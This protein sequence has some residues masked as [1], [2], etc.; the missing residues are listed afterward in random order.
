[1]TTEDLL[2]AEMDRQ[3][4]TDNALRAGIAAIVGGES[5][6][7]PQSERSY[8]GTNNARIRSIFQSAL[9]DKSDAFIDELK[10]DDVEF[11]NY[12][13]GPEG[14]G[15]ALGN[16]HPGDGYRYRGRGGIQLTG[17]GN[18]AKLGE[19]S[20]LDL[21]GDPDLV[22]EPVNSARIAVA[23][24]RWRYR[25]GGWEAMKDAVGNSFGSVD[26]RKNALFSRYSAS[27]EFDAPV[28]LVDERPVLRRGDRNSSVGRAQGRLKELG[29]YLHRV[30]ND[31]GPR[32]DRAV[33]DFQRGHGLVADG[34]IGR[35]TWSALLG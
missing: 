21:L 5:E 7:K 2:R 14:T 9:A 25:G 1:M 12:V 19:L 29:F 17:R 33:R 23:Y 24:M 8:R 34:V 27:G 16:T 3:R 31:F 4:V 15:H 6:F 10:A 20:G 35:D 11:F 26:E 13:Y 18:Y 22:N 28:D 30:D 32:T